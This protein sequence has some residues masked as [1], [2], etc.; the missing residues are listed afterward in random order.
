MAIQLDDLY[1]HLSLQGAE[2]RRLFMARSIFDHFGGVIAYGPLKGFRLDAE[3]SWNAADLG[4]KMFGLY[5]QEVLAMLEHRRGKADV[6]VNLGAA[7]GYYGVGAV[8]C[9]M[10]SKAVC[11]EATPEGRQVIAKTAALN[12]VADRID[13]RQQAAASF[14]DELRAGGC[15]PARCLVLCDIEGG[16]FDVFTPE[17]IA[18]LAQATLVIELHEFM[19]P[20]GDA[21]AK[22]LLE[23]LGAVFK[24][25]FA[26]MGARDLSPFPELV[27]VN[28]TDR[29]LICSEGRG[30]M[31][32][33]VLCEPR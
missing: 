25:S 1:L 29:W 13:I 16:E 7:D 33:W 24:L 15:D 10:F 20:D 21:R 27:N 17:C 32:T 2:S 23:A 6:L 18:K 3:S 28:D 30:R 5:E 26:T 4:S 11:Y 12:Q 19:V 8:K 9:G 22:V 14:P 31:M